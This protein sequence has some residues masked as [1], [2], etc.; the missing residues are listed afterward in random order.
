MVELIPYPQTVDLR[1]LTRD[2]RKHRRET[3]EVDFTG[4]VKIHGTNI[5]V[6]F[7]KDGGSPQ[8]QSRNRIITPESPATDNSGAAAFL[9]PWL[10]Q[11]R[12]ET[13]RALGTQ[14][15]D[16]KEVMIAGEYAGQGIQKGVGVSRLE[17]FYVVFGVRVDGLWMPG[18]VWRGVR[19]EQ[20]RVFNIFDFRTF[21]VRIDFTPRWKA[22]RGGAVR[23]GEGH[24]VEGIEQLAVSRHGAEGGG[25]GG[26]EEEEEEE[27]ADQDDETGVTANGEIEGMTQAVEDECPVAL[28]MGGVRNGV[29]EGI[30]WVEDSPV[31]LENPLKFKSKGP[32]HR[33]VGAKVPQRHG[34]ADD[35]KRDGVDRFVAYAVTDMRLRQGLDTLREGSGGESVAVLLLD[36]KNIPKLHKWVMTDVVKEEGDVMQEMCLTENDVRK[37]VVRRVRDFFEEEVE[38]VG[39]CN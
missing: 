39:E 1:R 29:G 27:D 9:T 8:I 33:I 3:T 6:I 19:V 5:T 35:A 24:C 38:E 30:V 34:P 16:W 31:P 7:R 25:G 21:R 12:R 15:A 4:T 32:K 10:A 26:G 36:K 37:E 18:E 17:K 22:E 14:Y 28:E 23:D 20:G 2:V 11:L 13:E